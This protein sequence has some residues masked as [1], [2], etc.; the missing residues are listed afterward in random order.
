MS[1]QGWAGVVL[2]GGRSS[3][4][5]RDKA[6]LPVQ[7]KP[8]ITHALDILRPHVD[9]LLIIGD[10]RKYDGF[11]PL[12][13]ADDTPGSGPLGGILTALRYAWHDRLLIL[14]CDMPKI[15]ASFIELLMARYE[16]GVNAVVAQCDGRLEPLAA[17]YHRSCRTV[18]AAQLAAGSLKLSDA[19]EQ[20]HTRYVQ[21]CPGEEGWPTDLFRN[22]NAPSDL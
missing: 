3:R 20:V 15:T 12:A 4:M 11:G 19:M 18:F 22:I 8:L 13:L 6:L 16:E 21:V 7:G 14:A 9:E 17:V 2:A 5:G 1:G 10:P